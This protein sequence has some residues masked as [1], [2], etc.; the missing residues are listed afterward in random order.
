MTKALGRMLHKEIHSTSYEVRQL[1]GGTLGDVRL[2]TGTAHTE[3]GQ[4]LPFEIV[5]KSQK[6]WERPGDPG[7]W[8]REFDLYESGFDSILSEGLRLPACYHRALSGGQSQI[9]MEYIRGRSGGALRLEDLET[10]AADLGRL[11][12]RL[13]PE[14]LREIPCLGDTGFLERE[15]SQWSPDTAEYRYLRSQ[16]CSLPSYLRR[17]LIK[18][19]EQSGFLFAELRKLPVVL[20]HRDFW[21]ENIFLSGGR[22]VLIDW[23]CAGWGFL[24]EDLASLIA[25]E[26]DPGLMDEYYRRLVPAYYGGAAESRDLPAKHYL[27]ELILIK[28]GYRLLQRY[29]FAATPEDREKSARALQFLFDL[30]PCL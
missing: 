20:C 4:D 19:Q 24:G 13:R 6:K 8:R 12:G 17:M 5:L 10:A 16:E 3:D 26:T 21:S 28:F 27:R 25:D 29:Q 2:F 15:Y 1:Q 23:D 22:T 30:E 14:H 9:W 18:T 7:S 11:Q